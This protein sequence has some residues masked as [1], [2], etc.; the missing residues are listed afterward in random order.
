MKVGRFV[1]DRLAVLPDGIKHDTEN[2]DKDHQA[3]D[4]HE[5]VQPDLFGGDAG[6]GLWQIKLVHARATRQVFD[7]G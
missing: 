2:D 1:A 5:P 6:D 7:D 3:D 4:H